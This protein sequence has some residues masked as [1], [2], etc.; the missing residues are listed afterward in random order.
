MGDP[1]AAAAAGGGR[2]PPLAYETV[3]LSVDGTTVTLLDQRCLPHTL[4]Y[5][6][7]SSAAAV[8][9]AI[10]AMV[11]RGAPAI[12][13]TAAYG[14]AVGAAAA[15]AAHPADGRAFRADVDA[16]AAVLRAARPT[17][18]NLGWA[19]DR[20]LRLVPP[21]DGGGD[22]GDGGGGD[23][24]PHTPAAVAAALTADA[25]AIAR[26]DVAINRRMGALGAA[27]LPP[28]A[29]VLHHCNTGA[30]ATVG[31]GTAL[32]VIRSAAAA[33]AGVS[34]WVNETR[35]RLQGA[36]LT[37]WELAAAGIPHTL[38]VDSAAAVLLRDG[39][40]DAVTVGADRVAANGDTAN[41]IGTLAVAIAAAHYKV[42]FYV[43]APASTVDL[44]CATGAG[45]PV[46]ERAAEEVTHPCGGGG[47][48]DG[49]APPGTRV[50]NPAFDVTAA[51]LITAIVTEEGVAR[52]PFTESLPP[53]V[54][55]AAAKV[56]R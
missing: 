35:P 38:T 29:R 53:L 46:E 6:H 48:A 7:L 19:L 23:T 36:R 9:D 43:V 30:L 5:V 10:R 55:A 33:D 25:R 18:V 45:I 32:G 4:T 40:V 21:A 56:R 51:D 8:A 27:L 44:A 2:P 20:L 52:P 50:F 47:D 13:A 15:A 22:G 41:K 42:P 26:E 1:A 39:R 49:V 14:L 11:V 3:A 16:A 24:T 37:A 12:G 34:V 31:H 54:A 28:A 17:A